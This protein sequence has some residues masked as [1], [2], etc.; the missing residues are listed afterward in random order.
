[1]LHDSALYKSIIDI[2]TYILLQKPTLQILLQYC[3]ALVLF[4]YFN[5]SANH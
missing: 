4:R 3:N 1:M 2:D 5:K